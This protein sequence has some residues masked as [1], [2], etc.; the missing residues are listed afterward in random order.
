MPK[1]FTRFERPVVSGII[2]NPESS[3]TFQSAKDETDINLIIKTYQ[4]TGTLPNSKPKAFSTRYPMFGDFSQS[5]DYTSVVFALDASKRAFESLPSAI[6]R[7]FNNDPAEL[8]KFLEDP[9]NREEAEKLGLIEKQIQQIVPAVKPTETASSE[10]S[11]VGD[12]GTDVSTSEK[13]IGTI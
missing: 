10:K 1:F 7:R 5:T 8:V 4:E 13:S 9:A 6:R 2:F 3:L 12:V 11:A